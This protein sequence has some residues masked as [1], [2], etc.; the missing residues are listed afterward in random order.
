MDICRQ[1]SPTMVRPRDEIFLDDILVAMV[2]AD[3]NIIIWREVS[4]VSIGG[5]E[6][7]G[8]RRVRR[9]R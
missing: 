2:A 6:E 3:T 5:R 4:K 1:A 7:R 9:R 8:D